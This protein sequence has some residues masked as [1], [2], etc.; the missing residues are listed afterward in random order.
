MTELTDREAHEKQKLKLLKDSPPFSGDPYTVSNHERIDYKAMVFDDLWIFKVKGAYC[1]TI[2][3]LLFGY[4][5]DKVIRRKNESSEH[6]YSLNLDKE[7]GAIKVGKGKKYCEFLTPFLEEEDP[8]PRAKIP[9]TTWDNIERLNRLFEQAVKAVVLKEDGNPPVVFLKWF[10]RKGFVVPNGLIPA[11]KKGDVKKAVPLLKKMREFFLLSKGHGKIESAPLTDKQKVE[12]LKEKYISAAVVI[13][14]KNPTWTGPM[15]MKEPSL[16]NLIRSSGLDES[17]LPSEANI[18]K[19]WMREV[20]I[21]VNI[22]SKHSR[23]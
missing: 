20:R 16:K 6:T 5:N 4:P 3:R 10:E 11:M 21:E 14:Q 13:L 8:K 9:L 12:K 17:K 1:Q 15:L 7:S 18:L 22:E 2:E 19:R 23:K